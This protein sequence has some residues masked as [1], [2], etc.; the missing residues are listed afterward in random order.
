MVGTGWIFLGGIGERALIEMLEELM[1]QNLTDE[2]LT[3]FA[4]RLLEIVNPGDS[5]ER[6]FKAFG[7]FVC[8]VADDFPKETVQ[9]L[10]VLK[11]VITRAKAKRL[12]LV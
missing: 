8:L 10:A 7:A 1:E 9:Y 12:R 4:D 2:Q 3:W 11:D 6:I 5:N